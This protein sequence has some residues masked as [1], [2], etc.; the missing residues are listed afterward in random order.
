MLN[1]K[2]QA[3]G[4]VWHDWYAGVCCRVVCKTLSVESVFIYGIT[5]EFDLDSIEILW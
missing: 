4:I 1:F 5:E 2:I 3:D